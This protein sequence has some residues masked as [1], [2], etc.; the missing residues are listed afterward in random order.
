MSSKGPPPSPVS[1]I[2]YD[3]ERVLVI[4]A[5]ISLGVVVGI[6]IILKL[7]YLIFGKL[8]IPGWK[9]FAYKNREKLAL[10]YS[11]SVISSILV[12]FF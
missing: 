7:I 8:K 10:W 5:S 2:Y 6:S 1:P 12:R 11:T 9:F 3:Q 4:Y